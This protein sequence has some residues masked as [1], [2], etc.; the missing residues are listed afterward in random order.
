MAQ[1]NDAEAGMILEGVAPWA[2]LAT[3]CVV[4]WLATPRRV[5]SPQ[6]FDGRRSDGALPGLWLVAVSA[7]ITWIF[8]KSIANAA[9][10]AYAFGITGGLGYALYYLSFVVAGVAIYVLRTRGHYRLLRIFSSTNTGCSVR[11]CFC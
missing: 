8:A 1:P 4:T 9:D 5:T 2:V 3:A 11:G 6:F 10:L 7:A